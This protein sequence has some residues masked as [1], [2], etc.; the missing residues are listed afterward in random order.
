M[1]GLYLRFLV[2]NITMGAYFYTFT[3]MFEVFARYKI[4]R[5]PV[6]TWQKANYTKVKS[7]KTR[8]GVPSR[9]ALRFLKFKFA[10]F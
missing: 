6:L 9:T 10:D 2:S 4:Q 1:P 7:M 3:E 8:D 5:F